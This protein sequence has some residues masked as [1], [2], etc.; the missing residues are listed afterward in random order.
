MHW[1]VNANSVVFLFS[2]G[3]FAA[4]EAPA[5]STTSA[6]H[7]THP[8]PYAT[9]QHEFASNG[10][11]LSSHSFDIWNHHRKIYPV[12]DSG[13]LT[14]FNVQVE[15]LNNRSGKEFHHGK[16]AECSW[17]CDSTIFAFTSYS[18]KLIFYWKKG[19]HREFFSNL[20]IISMALILLY[21]WFY[22]QK[23]GYI[24]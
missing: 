12:K 9:R 22:K 20:I 3:D 10:C 17:H 7:V 14:C 8:S 1:N 23:L 15:I 2:G 6:G 19:I 4:Q 11:C 18:S 13:S 16:H 5:I 21:N 24:K